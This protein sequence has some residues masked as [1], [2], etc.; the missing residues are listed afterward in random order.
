[1]RDSAKV[2]LQEWGDA[3]SDATRPGAARLVENEI[4]SSREPGGQTQASQLG[5][6]RD[7]SFAEALKNL[8]RQAPE[9]VKPP[10]IVDLPQSNL[11]VERT[12]SAP[13]RFEEPLIAVQRAA[14][15]APR[16]GIPQP[17]V[18][19]NAAFPTVVT[20]QP[21]ILP[22][23]P[24]AGPESKGAKKGN[25][26]IRRDRYDTADDIEVLPSWRGQYKKK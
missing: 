5:S 25:S 10:T 3:A 1:M 6:L 14:A 4:R 23:K 20:A 17:A 22:P 2:R 21:E 18:A 12:P 11:E 16:T 9:P 19:R 26:P 8:P 24:D 13:A 7:R 15:S